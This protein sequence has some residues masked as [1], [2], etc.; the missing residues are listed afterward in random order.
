MNEE[1]YQA[2]EEEKRRRLGTTMTNDFTQQGCAKNSVHSRDS[3]KQAR[4]S[5]KRKFEDEM[6]DVF[7]FSAQENKLNKS[8]LER[9]LS[10]TSSSSIGRWTP[11]NSVESSEKLKSEGSAIKLQRP[12]S[13]SKNFAHKF[14]ESVLQTTRQKEFL[15]VSSK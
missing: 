15:R 3:T 10:G 4:D 5:V 2:I 12:N 6:D 13:L 11:R 1:I 9:Q 14:H 8:G 7:S